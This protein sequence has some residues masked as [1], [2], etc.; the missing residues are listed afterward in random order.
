MLT[1]HIS[2]PVT[3]SRLKTTVCW[4]FL[5]DFTDWLV[6]KRYASSTIQLYAFGLLSLGRWLHS[7]GLSIGEFDHDACNAYRCELDAQGKLRHRGGKFK[8]AFRGV[9]R[10]HEFLVSTE[11]VKPRPA[12]EPHVLIT[13]FERWILTHKGV[14]QITLTHHLRYI[15][16]FLQAVGDKP[17]T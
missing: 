5:D 10:F 11:V 16:P 6:S 7:N 15:L 14:R 17:G 9:R 2:S 12:P 8:T 13:G 1:Q 4:P 3:L